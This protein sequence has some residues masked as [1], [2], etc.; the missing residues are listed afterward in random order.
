MPEGF[1]NHAAIERDV[2]MPLQP[3]PSIRRELLRVDG[4]TLAADVHLP[5]N[6]DRPPVVF[7]HG[8]LASLDLAAELFV[9]PASEPWIGLSLPGHYPGALP[10]ACTAA[11]L[12]EELFVRLS[13]VALQQLVGNRRVI[14]TGWSTGGFAALNLAI[15]HPARVAAVASLAG[16]ASGRRIAGM[17]RWLVWLAGRPLGRP[18][19]RLGMRL[20]AFWPGAYSSL[21]GCLAADARAAARVPAA[22]ISQMHRDF[23]RHD[24]DS[25]VTALAAL[26]SLDITDRLAEI[27]VPA[28][29]A[30]GA[31]DPAVPRAET[32]RIA[33]AIPHAT[34]RV[35]ERA[36]HLFFSEWP[37]YREDFAAWRRSL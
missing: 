24:A 2:V 37:R 28:W 22:M 31:A 3:S 29:I 10:P 35:Y 12:D 20:A 16:F 4:H 8:I 32:E 14:A 7:L 23:A 33:R 36:G 1:R 30:G 15:R 6:D 13:E 19:I 18:A 11:D 9:D 5:A 26:W 27:G 25:L 17:M 21:L 34:L